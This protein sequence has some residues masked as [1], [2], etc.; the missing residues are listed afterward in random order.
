MAREYLLVIAGACLLGAVALF[1]RE[2]LRRARY[3]PR[4]TAEQPAVA[5][6]QGATEQW[7]PVAEVGKP[8]PTSARDKLAIAEAQAAYWHGQVERWRAEVATEE[9][10]PLARALDA[11]QAQLLD[12]LRRAGADKIKTQ[13]LSRSD[14]RRIVRS[15]APR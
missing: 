14:I 4:H 7:S 12:R 5:E 3:E 8:K 9:A 6:H 10:Q 15:G 2:H 13:E 1:V 11:L